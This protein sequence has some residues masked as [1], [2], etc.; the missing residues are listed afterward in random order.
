MVRSV[1]FSRCFFSALE[2]S[3]R[4]RETGDPATPWSSRGMIAKMRRKRAGA[5]VLRERGIG[6]GLHRS[7]SSA[8]VRK[9]DRCRR[10]SDAILHVRLDENERLRGQRI[11]LAGRA[12]G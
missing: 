8:R 10:K 3:G 9:G 5:R 4:Q 6:C 2:K 7:S 12:S 1:R 11:L